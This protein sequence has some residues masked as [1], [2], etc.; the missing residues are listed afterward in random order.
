MPAPHIR[1][2]DEELETLRAH[3]RDQQRSLTSLAHDLVV[4]G[5][6]RA[7]HAELILGASA[8]VMSLSQDLLKRLADR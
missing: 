7:Q 5:S 1:F 8:R 4:S 3:A 6:E 2:T